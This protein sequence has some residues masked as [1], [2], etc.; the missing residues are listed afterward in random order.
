MKRSVVTILS[1]AAVLL[2]PVLAGAVGGPEVI[3]IQE[4]KKA[5][6]P[7][8]FPHHEHQKRLGDCKVCHH[9]QEA[10][11]E[12]RACAQC[13]GKVKEAPAFKDA[14]HKRCKGCHKK[15]AAAG[16]P[17]PTKCMQCH[18]K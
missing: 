8:V 17:A 18:K 11:K 15:E 16:K 7:V 13:H 14:M 3:T 10:G 5:M 1:V 2:V 12:P 9:K 4:V 6:P